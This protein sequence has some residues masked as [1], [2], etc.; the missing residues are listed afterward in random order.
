V[1]VSLQALSCVS[2]ESCV[3][4][5]FHLFGESTTDFQQFET[6]NM[7]QTCI[8][9]TVP[10]FVR[11]FQ[12][13]LALQTSNSSSTYLVW[14]TWRLENLDDLD[15]SKDFLLYVRQDPACNHHCAWNSN[16]W[17]RCAW[18]CVGIS[19]FCG[20]ATV[21]TRGGRPVTWIGGGG[22]DPGNLARMGML[23]I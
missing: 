3:S 5:A 11:D 15:A 22:Q 14:L 23:Q 8:P 18:G 4:A 17:T 12:Q 20:T 1:M 19:F 2:S 13:V 7:F 10:V 6:S 21:A 16:S 9:P